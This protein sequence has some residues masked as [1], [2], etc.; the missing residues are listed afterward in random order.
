MDCWLCTEFLCFSARVRRDLIHIG[1]PRCDG[2]RPIYRDS[3]VCR[4]VMDD[5]GVCMCE[6]SRAL[7]LSFGE[8]LRIS[9]ALAR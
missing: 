2:L 9:F 4:N 8:E 1:T 5:V 6:I 3:R 7:I